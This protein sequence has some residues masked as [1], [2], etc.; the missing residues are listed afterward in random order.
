MLAANRILALTAIALALSISSSAESPAFQIIPPSAQTIYAPIAGLDEFASWQLAVVNRSPGPTPATI[1]LYSREGAVLATSQVTLAANETRDLDIRTLLPEGDTSP[2]VGGLSISFTG[3]PHGVG[4]QVTLSR[5][6]GF[7][8]VDAPVFPDALY[9]S[10]TA[11]A[12]WWAPRRSRSYLVL[13]SSSADSLTVKITDGK[14]ELE[15]VEVAPHGTVVR[16][17]DGDID[18]P[19]GVDSVHVEGTGAPGTLRITGYTVSDEARFVNTIR[20]YDPAT[21]SETAMYANGIHFSG[22]ANHLAVKNLSTQS[23]RV[24]ATIFPLASTNPAMEIPPK[25]VEPGVTAELDLSGIASPAALDGAAIKV[26]STGPIGSVIASLVNHSREEHIVRAA[27]FKDIG[28]MSISTGAYPWRLDGEFDSRIYITNAGTVRAA[29]GG[30]ILP[31]NGPSYFVDSHYLDPGESA[32]FDIRQLRDEQIPDPRGVKLPK[33]ALVGQF[34]WST[35]FGD[36]TQRFIGRNE[37]VDRVSGISASFSCGGVCYCP[38]NTTSASFSPGSS[39]TYVGGQVTNMSTVASQYTC[40][41]VFVDNYTV[42][43]GS[44]N[45]A[46]LSVL[47]LSSGAPSSTM[48]GLAGGSSSFY[49][50]FNGIS[51]AYNGQTQQCFVASTPQLNP[52]G[53]GTV[54]GVTISGPSAVLISTSV[55]GSPTIQLTA[56]GTPPGGT[57]TWSSSS[58]SV[59]LKNPST[60]TVTVSASSAGSSTL[61]ATYTENGIQGTAKQIVT[62]LVPK[63]LSAPTFKPVVVVNNG[64]V[65]DYFGNVLRTGYCGVYQNFASDLLD[66]SG[67]KIIT[68]NIFSFSE[69][70]S[71]YVST[72]GGTVPGGPLTSDQNTGIQRLADTQAFGGP[73]PANCPGTNDNESFDQTF[74]LKI[75]GTTYP[76]TTVRHI[77]RGNFSGTLNVNVTTTSP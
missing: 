50:P 30:H 34:S 26:E 42:T 25:S 47:S 68:T 3:A 8:N 33:D 29:F 28:D 59:T 27:P 58:S 62:V 37:L 12:V 41:G 21:A 16:S 77:S 69:S 52:G 31:A 54:V 38:N 74:S 6:H 44:W 39:T 5:Y 57:Y 18:R 53:N 19:E 75:D 51:Y 36:G 64:N 55:T 67:N 72:F 46:T 70:F 1:T 11:D 35:I 20:A 4:A 63:S 32:V 13:G 61:T 14:G 22:G 2:K 15:Q 66:Q 48:R 71:N 7:G 10:N 40:M 43:P 23:L 9:K 45:V 60:A 76:L 24:S 49:T 56:T 73:Y 65:V 17:L